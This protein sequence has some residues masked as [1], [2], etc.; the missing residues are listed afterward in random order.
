MK[1]KTALV[2]GVSSDVGEAT[3]ERLAMAG[4]KV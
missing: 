1:S 2:T 3:A 4:Y